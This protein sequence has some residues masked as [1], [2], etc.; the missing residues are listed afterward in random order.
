MKNLLC[1]LA[2][3]AP[4]AVT[5][6]GK[7]APAPEKPKAEKKADAP[8][9]GDTWATFETSAGTIVV[10]LRPD[11]CPKTVETFVMLA[12]G[13]KEWTDPASGQKLK[14]PLYDGTLFHRVIPGFM[15]QGGDPLSRG[16]ALGAREAGGRPIGTGGPG[17]DYADELAG[18]PDPF[19]KACQL[20]NANHGP[21][22]NGSQ[23]FITEGS[24]DQVA[25]LRPRPC[26]SPGGLCGY[27]RFG[28]GVC[29]CELVPKI[30]AAGNSQT[31]LKSVKI[32]RGKQPACK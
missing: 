12:E 27:T 2:L 25:Q 19:A 3:A 17:F 9:K 21:N 1:A 30:A 29:G 28:E 26:S 10:K 8:A 13:T 24:G 15:I 14:K 23:F 7:A 4:F 32:T 18:D 20:A 31:I 11:L 22:T 5:A 6:Q 16:Q